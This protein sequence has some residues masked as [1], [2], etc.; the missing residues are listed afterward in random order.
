MAQLKKKEYSRLGNIFY[1]EI[2]QGEEVVNTS[3][4]QQDIGGTA[5]CTNITMTSGS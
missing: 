2:Q 5:A 1:L 3:C 4:F